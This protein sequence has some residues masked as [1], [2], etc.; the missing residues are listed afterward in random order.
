MAVSRENQAKVA[1]L[2]RCVDILETELKELFFLPADQAEPIKQ[3]VE[4]LVKRCEVLAPEEP[5]TESPEGA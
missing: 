1:R 3:T 2:K 5:E 4:F